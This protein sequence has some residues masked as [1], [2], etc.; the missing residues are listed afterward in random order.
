MFIQVLRWFADKMSMKPVSVDAAGSR[1]CSKKKAG[2]TIVELMVVIIIVNLLSGVAVPKIT[3]LIEKT[4]QK[5]DLLQLY[6]LRDALNRALYE[7]DAM[8]IDTTASCGGK[9]NSKTNLAKF[10]ESKNGVTLF[11]MELHDK[12]SVN[13]QGLK[14]NRISDSQNMCG[15]L[16]SEGYWSQAFRDAGFGA[17]ADIIIARADNDNFSK[18]P[19]DYYLEDEK[20]G[21]DTWHRTFPKK[22]IFISR[23]MNGDPLAASGNGGQTRLLFK[24][25][26]TGG[27][28]NS[29]SL[30]VFITYDSV[31]K[32]F[33][34]R[35]GVCFSTQASGCR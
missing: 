30:E 8:R 16:S 11:I 19:G 25:R 33:E 22:P 10:L 1:T 31:D 12:F 3:D 13:Y 26:W 18:H 32:P 34:T 29:H 23:A 9:K 27:N 2:F 20:V 14:E 4:K 6:Y 17:I 7:D 24:M 15:L 35:L 5:I 28:P 21:K